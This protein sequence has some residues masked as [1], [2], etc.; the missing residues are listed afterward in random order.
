MSRSSVGRSR[1]DTEFFT[2]IGLPKVLFS[3]KGLF[4]RSF[5]LV[6]RYLSNEVHALARIQKEA[7]RRFP[8][9]FQVQ[10]RL[11]EEPRGEAA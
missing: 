6:A 9:L 2:G 11:I 7:P 4:T 1:I 8:I 5:W 10:V 3:I